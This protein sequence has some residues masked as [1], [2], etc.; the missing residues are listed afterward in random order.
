MRLR[1]GGS[2][3]GDQRTDIAAARFMEDVG[4]PSVP[5][6]EDW[7]GPCDLLGLIRGALECKRTGLVLLAA[8]GS[9][10]EVESSGC[11]KATTTM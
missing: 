8:N 9:G 1:Q 11:P 5:R 3:P 2:R 4:D 10:D 6:E 7:N